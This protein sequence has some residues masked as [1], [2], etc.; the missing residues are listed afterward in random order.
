[1]TVEYNEN[2]QVQDLTDYSLRLQKASISSKQKGEPS[3][4]KA[5]YKQTRK[6]VS[7]QMKWDVLYLSLNKSL[8]DLY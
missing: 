5:T 8:Q 7:S 2:W 4:C 3:F 6:R 1:M